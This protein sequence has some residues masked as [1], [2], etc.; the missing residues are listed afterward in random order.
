MYDKD[1]EFNLKVATL[2]DINK[3]KTKQAI[4]ENLMEIEL[5]QGSDSL[6]LEFKA[7]LNNLKIKQMFKLNNLDN[8]M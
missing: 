3:A 5:L 6:S 2:N 8:Y 7:W 1:F 4:R